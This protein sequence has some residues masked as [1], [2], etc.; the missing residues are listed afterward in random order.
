[1]VQQLLYSTIV[2]GGINGDL[3][4]LEQARATAS[5]I[6]Q[7]RSNEFPHAAVNPVSGHLYCNFR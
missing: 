5:I 3:G 1:M 4:L 7:F 6:Q 2:A